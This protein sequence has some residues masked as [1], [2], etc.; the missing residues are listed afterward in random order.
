MKIG[1]TGPYCT[2]NFGDWAMLVNNIFDFGVDNEYVIFTYSSHFPHDVIEHYFKENRI[3]L[4]EVK[5]KE[6]NYPWKQAT[7]LD[8]ILSIK[9]KE[10]IT[11]VVRRLDMLIVNGGGWIAD[12]W[13]KRLEKFY[14]V[15]APAI[16]AAHWRVPVR[17]MAQGVGPFID[18]KETMRF[19][20]NYFREDTVFAVRDQYCS[21]SYLKELIDD[22]Y[23]ITYLPDDLA[24]VNPMLM[25]KHEKI[26]I[27]G[28]YIV[29]VINDSLINVKNNLDL[30]VNFSH[31]MM[32]N[33][34]LRA[35]FLP[36]DLV[37]FGAEQSELLHANIQD[38]ILIDINGK[39][40]IPIEDTISIIEGAA[41]LITERHHAAVIAMQ[42]RTPFILKLDT[43]MHFYAYNK[44]HGV[45]EEFLRNIVYDDGLF[46]RTNWDD[47]LNYVSE[48][49]ENIIQ[50]QKMIF[51]N[52][53]YGQN[54]DT[55]DRLRQIYIQS[56]L[57]EEQ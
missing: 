27:N 44:A 12:H 19:F 18:T 5:T 40:F 50:Q 41:M 32:E 22:K 33:H 37:W 3:V 13:C 20:L 42:T 21:A 10:E 54:H 7:P 34:H 39:K 38:S 49:Y 16:I 24:I 23:K 15:M 28:Q 4:L 55:M 14:K 45:L 48:E 17:F 47:L 51:S 6:E 31:F 1:F 25:P 2:A 43:G 52:K 36:F 11:N 26:D 8:C 57:K 29:F 56:L 53:E 46:F 9:N 30:Y 35:V